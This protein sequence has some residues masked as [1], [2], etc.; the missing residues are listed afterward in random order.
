MKCKLLIFQQEEQ[1]LRLN[2]FEN[3]EHEFCFR[4]RE[5]YQVSTWNSSPETYNKVNCEVCTKLNKT[6]EAR[7]E[8]VETI[9][10]IKD[11]GET[12]LNLQ[13]CVNAVTTL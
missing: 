12:F 2:F 3:F 10:V 1:T 5:Q 8:G 4:W 6:L 7:K 11:L 9:E 13:T